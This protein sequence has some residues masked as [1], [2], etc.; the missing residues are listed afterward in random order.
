M[1]QMHIFYMAYIET[2]WPNLNITNFRAAQF[3]FLGEDVNGRTYIYTGY[4][5]VYDD[6]LVFAHR[7]DHAVMDNW[8]RELNAPHDDDGPPCKRRRIGDYEPER[9][10]PTSPEYCP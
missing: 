5:D 2:F 7:I 1:A 3:Q 6:D 8:E 9:Y 4:I 10:S